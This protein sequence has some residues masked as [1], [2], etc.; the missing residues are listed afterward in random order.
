MRALQRRT[1]RGI[2]DTLALGRWRAFGLYVRSLSSFSAFTLDYLVMCR[3]GTAEIERRIAG[4]SI[5]GLEHMEQALASGRP[6]LVTTMHMGNFQLGFLKLVD[7]LR[8]ARTLSVFKMSLNDRNEDVLFQAFAKLGCPPTAMRAGEDGGRQAYLALRKGD[9]VAITIDLELQVKSRSVVR[10]FDRP[11]H[12]Q[13]GPATIAALTRA[14]IVPVV[15]YEDRSGRAIV[16]VEPP[17][18]TDIRATGETMPIAIQRLTQH[19]AATLERWIRIDPRQV[20]AWSA[21]AETL[22]CPLP[23]APEAAPAA[24]EATTAPG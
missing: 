14:L 6:I 10:F 15:N 18:E 13:N 23:P 21:I 9:I 1:L 12:M 17:V 5:Q 11:C 8:P 7:R 19:L 20:H 16:R 2:A 24:A 22:A 3:R 4:L